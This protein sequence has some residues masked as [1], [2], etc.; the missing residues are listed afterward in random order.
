[1]IYSREIVLRCHMVGV[2]RNSCGLDNF[3]RGVAWYN[4][5]IVLEQFIG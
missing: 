3:K 5:F 2:W 1:M 4:Y